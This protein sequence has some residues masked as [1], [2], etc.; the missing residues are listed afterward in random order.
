LNKRI[1]EEKNK[2]LDSHN[3]TIKN[4]SLNK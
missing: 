4:N 2:D 3:K 1:K